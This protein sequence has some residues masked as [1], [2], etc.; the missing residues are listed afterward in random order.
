M[1]AD[2]EVIGV[3]ATP[4]KP[5][6]LKKLQDGVITAVQLERY[7]DARR[8]IELAI[9]ESETAAASERYDKLL[10]ENRKLQEKLKELQEPPLTRGLI[11]GPSPDDERNVLIG[12]G[13]Q[14]L[15]VR[16]AADSGL[17]PG[18]LQ[19]G[20]EAW[21]SE[22]RH[23]TKARPPSGSGEATEVTAI[24]EDGR[25]G[26]KGHG[27][28]EIV[29]DRILPLAATA[30]QVGDRVRI[31]PQLAVALEKL[32]H[33]ENKEL[34]LEA[35]PDV[36]Y[37]DIGGLDEQ[38]E[39]IREA[40]EL[41]YLYH[42]LFQEYG[43]K[44]PKG[45]LLYG[46]PGC[47]KT[48]IAKAIANSLTREIRRN[49]E[50]IAE[51][52][53]LLHKLRH[54]DAAGE[55]AA[56]DGPGTA[57]AAWRLRVH[58]A[59]AQAIEEG[60]ASPLPDEMRAEMEVELLRFLASRG[61]EVRDLEEQLT[62]A[63]AR[64]AEKPQAYFMS[65]KGPELLNKYVGE[66]EH[67]IRKLFLQAKRKASPATPVIMF[68]DEIEALFRRRGSRVSS[69]V[70]ST[71]VPQFLSEMDGVEVLSDVII[72]GATN[73]QDLLDPAILRPGR[74]DA[75]IKIERPS[76]D[77]ARSIFSKYI[78]PALPIAEDE[79]AAA[80]SVEAAIDNLIE[81]AVALLYSD[82]SR[83]HVAGQ[84]VEGGAKTL[85]CRDFISGAMIES[86][87]SRHK[88]RALKR[89]IQAGQRG[90]SWSDLFESIREELEQNKDQLVATTLNLSE[91]GLTIELVLAVGGAADR[92]RNPWLRPIERP[93]VRPK[94]AAVTAIR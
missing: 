79:V 34:E 53:S 30:L 9:Q 55:G 18:D 40:I 75:K 1:D 64:L 21:L 57:Y 93:W 85:T 90:L 91:E 4:M 48:L 28:E 39:H 49:Q 5:E 42:H 26:V 78:V 54:D 13:G 83:Y 43:L 69:D 10:E 33:Q 66:T 14:R 7:Q 46:P 86:V 45:I 58:G 50:D 29:V 73:R 6:E 47:G 44:R 62:S 20:W 37:E 24:L 56:G 27:S 60:A 88:R 19:P 67:S 35:V 89:E 11:L 84:Q 71:I 63:Q 12:C 25:L 16:I 76:R 82:S 59:A 65:I 80:G 3:G 92:P 72:I 87:V 31:D 22:D 94:A 23:I 15:E 51:T 81:Q 68:F 74:L 52:L 32:P 36:T 77:A 2:A 38:I 61:I 8:L 41:P 70:E 17:S